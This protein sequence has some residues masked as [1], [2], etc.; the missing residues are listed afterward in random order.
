[1]RITPQGDPCIHY[2]EWVCSKALDI[3]EK[4]YRNPVNICSVE[5]DLFCEHNILKRLLFL[6]TNS[7]RSKQLL[8]IPAFV[9]VFNDLKLNAKSIGA[10]SGF[11]YSLFIKL[12]FFY[13][14]DLNPERQP[15]LI[16]KKCSQNLFFR[17]LMLINFF[18]QLLQ[19]KHNKYNFAT[20]KI[21]KTQLQK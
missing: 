8:W 4:T 20:L 1:M 15:T 5:E 13:T 17:S 12:S 16:Q 10:G 3:A 2:R 21:W 18:V 7:Y 9:D 19:R 6:L 14:Q 11:I